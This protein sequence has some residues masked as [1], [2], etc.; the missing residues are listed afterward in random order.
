MG[1][2]KG[3]SLVIVLFVTTIVMLLGT[4]LLNMSTSEYLMGSYARDYTAA[5]YLAEGGIQK[6]LVILKENP[7]YRGESGWQNLDT[8]QFKFKVS[9]ENGEMVKIAST[10]KAN[11]AEVLINVTAQVNVE[12]DEEADVDPPPVN[13]KIQVV[14]WDYAGPN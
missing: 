5:Y 7:D 8:G 1:S 14:N 2:N 10:G 11:K 6:A 9:T 3:I 4:V 13:V 12:I